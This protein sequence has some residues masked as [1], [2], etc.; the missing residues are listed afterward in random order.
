MLFN[1]LIKIEI[2]SRLNC[3]DIIAYHCIFPLMVTNGL[4]KNEIKIKL[5]CRNS[6]K[7]YGYCLKVDHAPVDKVSSRNPFP[8]HKIRG[9]NIPP[10]I[11]ESKMTL[12]SQK[13]HQSEFSSSITLSSYSSSSSSSSSR[14]SRSTS[15]SSSSTVENVNPG[16]RKQRLKK[17]SKEEMKELNKN[18]K[19]GNEENEENEVNVRIPLEEASIN[20]KVIK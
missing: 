20:V 11:R 19:D 15:R 10:K 16:I 14:G 12:K 17:N 6:R 2:E 8:P 7:I 13:L 5:T 1:S 3:I 9:L 4:F 18:D